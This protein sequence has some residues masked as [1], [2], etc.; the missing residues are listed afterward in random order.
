VKEA[1]ARLMIKFP[2]V[3]DNGFD[4]WKRYGVWAWPTIV[5]VDKKGVIRYS[6]VGEGAY[7]KTESTIKQLLADGG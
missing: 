7:Q 6:H 5:V 3:Q 4:I 2:V 1:T